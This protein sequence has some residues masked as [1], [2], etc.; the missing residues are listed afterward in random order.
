MKKLVIVCFV[1]FMGS[2]SSSLAQEVENQQ[3]KFEALTRGLTQGKPIELK[4]LEIRARIHEPTVI[5]VLD[6]P[7]LE[8]NFPEP[9]TE[10]SPRIYDPI[11]K[12]QL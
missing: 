7:K 8:I 12:N 6:R 2:I 5:Y 11:V 4:A 9:K 10:F 3:E 1:F